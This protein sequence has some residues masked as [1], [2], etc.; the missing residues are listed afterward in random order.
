MFTTWTY[1]DQVASTPVLHINSGGTTCRYSCK[2]LIGLLAPCEA[3]RSTLRQGASKAFVGSVLE[4]VAKCL[5]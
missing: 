5:T 2:E 1:A 3:N 4:F